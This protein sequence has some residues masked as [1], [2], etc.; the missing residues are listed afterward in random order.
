M[1]DSSIAILTHLRP[2]LAVGG[3]CIPVSADTQY[4]RW[5]SSPVSLLHLLFTGAP[6][7]ASA[8][9]GKF[10]GVQKVP[11]AVVAH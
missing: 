2:T 10:Q 5:W 3:L 11:E 6:A 7:A 9:G 8:C 1:A 4:V